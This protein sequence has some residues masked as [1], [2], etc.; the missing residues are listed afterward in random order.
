MK[1]FLIYLAFVSLVW[2]VAVAAGLGLVENELSGFLYFSVL[3]VFNLIFLSLFLHYL[4]LFLSKKC[5]NS[6]SKRLNPIWK[7]IFWMSLKLG[8]L[9]LLFYLLGHSDQ[10]SKIGIFLGLMTYFIVPIVSGLIWNFKAKE[11]G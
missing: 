3:I 8:G 5:Q 4:V 7:L 9:G 10:Y 2:I 11:Q 1:K 6:V